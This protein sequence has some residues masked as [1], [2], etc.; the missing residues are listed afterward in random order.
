LKIQSANYKTQVLSEQVDAYKSIVAQGKQLLGQGHYQE[1]MQ[2][3]DSALA[4]FPGARSPRIK[5]GGS[6]GASPRSQQCYDN[7][8][9]NNILTPRDP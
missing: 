4:V 7:R 3:F 9:I 1:A 6:I 5:T 2:T 8:T